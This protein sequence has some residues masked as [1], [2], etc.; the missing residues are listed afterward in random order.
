[1]LVLNCLL[2]AFLYP[3]FS[4]CLCFVSFFYFHFFSLGFGFFGSFS[5]FNQ[6]LEDALAQC[7]KVW[8]T[9]CTDIRSC[10]SIYPGRFIACVLL[11]LI[12][13]YFYVILLAFISF[14]L[15]CL[16]P[17]VIFVFVWFVFFFW[18]GFFSSFIGSDRDL[19]QFNK[20]CIV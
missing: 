5:A 14:Y 18:L 15:L 7:N 11:F 13:S 2:L 9:V 19:Q 12:F 6:D 8:I 3:F 1:M 17:F 4:F 20:F 10:V 16:L